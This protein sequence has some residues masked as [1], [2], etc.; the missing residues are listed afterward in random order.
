MKLFYTK[1]AEHLA[2]KIK[3]KKGKYIISSFPDGE[4]Y[5]KINENVKNKRVLVLAAT[6]PPAENLLELLFLL[7]ALQG[8]GARI[9]L[10]FTYFG[11][12]RQ[13][14]AK[15]GEALASQRICSW[16]K[17]FKWQNIAVLHPH[18]ERLKQFLK[19]KEILPYHFFTSVINREDVVVAPDK[20][21]SSL[22]KEI[23]KRCR[24]ARAEIEKVR[25]KGKVKMLSFHGEVN[26]KRAVIVD[27]MIST[28]NTVIKAAELLK[29]KGAKE[30]VVAA[31]HG[32]FADKALQKLEKSPIT[33]IYVTNSLPQKTRS[34]KVEIMD[35]APFLEKHIKEWS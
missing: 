27:D 26:G 23:S 28:G 9:Y 6:N 29:R 24:C 31:T 10:F 4:L 21:A 22:A 32:I 16:L 3:L 8:A 35:L 30:V 33:S 14:R 34:R 5:V 7:D 19:Y 20:G 1:S 25:L 13:D 2:K 17:G 12:A 11:Y 18:S 15:A